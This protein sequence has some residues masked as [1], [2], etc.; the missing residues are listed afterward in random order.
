MRLKVPEMEQL[1][2]N[3]RR[4]GDSIGAKVSVQASGVM[5]GLGEPVFDRLDADLAH[6]L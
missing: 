1:I 4:Q 3:L 2:D 5:P 6:A